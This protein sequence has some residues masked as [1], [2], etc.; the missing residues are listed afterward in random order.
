M[1]DFLWNLRNM[2]YATKK[3]LVITG[4]VLAAVA[5]LA[6]AIVILTRPKI[7][8]YPDPVRY[9]QGTWEFGAW[10]RTVY[11][12]RLKDDDTSGR[13]YAQSGIGSQDAVSSVEAYLYLLQEQYGFWLYDL[14]SVREDEQTWIL[15]PQGVAPD[16]KAMDRRLILSCGSDSSGTYLGFTQGEH[17][18]MVD[19]PYTYT[20]GS[21]S[22]TP[23]Q[24]EGTAQPSEALNTPAPGTSAP[25]A[26]PTPTPTP[27]PAPT[28]TPKPSSTVPAGTLPDPYT[29]FEKQIGYSGSKYDDQYWVNIRY[30]SEDPGAGDE[31]IQLL[32]DSRFGLTLVKS[33][34]TEHSYDKDMNAVYVFDYSGPASVGDVTVND[35]GPAPLIILA[36]VTYNKKYSDYDYWMTLYYAPGSFTFDDFGDRTTY[37]DLEK[38]HYNGKTTGIVDSDNFTD[39]T[40]KGNSG[41]GGST[42]SGIPS[43]PSGQQGKNRIICNKCWGH[44]KITCSACSGKGYTITGYVHTPNYGGGTSSRYDL[45]KRRN[46]Y[47]C[48]GT[49]TVECP[50]CHGEGYTYY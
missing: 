17:L 40:K 12:V 7:Y 34:R 22:V 48:N 35:D 18:E 37:H 23:S 43:A 9:L 27:T 30:K 10:D 15:Y 28:P 19:C 21:G 1:N 50:T 20:P 5:A 13:V 2:E 36:M 14:S 24:P 41:S 4:G 39:Y 29:F 11:T 44:K 31:Y 32:Q 33:E 47:K 49:G 42:S 6:V 46:C 16:D 38:S 26:T 3:K 8:E 25:T 45:E